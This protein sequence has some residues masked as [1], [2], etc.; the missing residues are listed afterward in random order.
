MK[1][2]VLNLIFTGKEICPQLSTLLG[3]AE[4]SSKQ[5]K[6]ILWIIPVILQK[7]FFVCVLGTEIAL[8]CCIIA[9]TDGLDLYLHVS[10]ILE[11]K[12]LFQILLNQK[13]VFCKNNLT[14]LKNRYSYWFETHF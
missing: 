11:S 13:Q 7:L 9:E 4:K 6:A 3:R 10:L 12:N 1:T 5:I 8:K 2:L 14:G